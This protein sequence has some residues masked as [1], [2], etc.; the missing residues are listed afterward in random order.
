VSTATDSP[1]T[2]RPTGRPGYAAAQWS[3]LGTYVQLVVAGPDRLDAARTEA[4]RLLAAVDRACSRF[5][6]DADLVRANHAAGSWVPVHPLLVAALTAALAAADETGG[7][8]DP[9]LGRA[10]E[11]LGY[12]RDF[13]ELPRPAAA[14]EAVPPADPAHVPTAVRPGAW[15]EVGVDPAGRVRVPDGVVLDLGAVGKA[16]AADLV[17]GSVARTVGVDCVISIG[18]DVAVGA[19]PDSPGHPWQVAVAE[20]PADRPTQ[21]VVLDRGGI[22]TS[23]TTHRR[24]QHAGATVHHLLDPRT[25]RP[26]ERSWRT[27]S[28]AAATC[29]AANTASTAALVLGAAAPAWL[30]ERGLPARLV[31]RDG[32]VTVVGGWPE[33]GTPEPPTP[34]RPGSLDEADEAGGA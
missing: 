21:L 16:F 3:A 31:A 8:V 25:G 12:D 22:A 14:P 13:A 23:T 4:E 20:G 28:V 24:W 30:A 6:P 18:G 15:R 27:V 2:S 33:G 17:A 29:V 34:A 1:S 19:T 32:T 9:T 11:T 7:L 5:R 26:V 10:L